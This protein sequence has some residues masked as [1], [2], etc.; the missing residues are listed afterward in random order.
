MEICCVCPEMAGVFGQAGVWVL[1]CMEAL[2][3]SNL[4]TYWILGFGRSQ[5]R[6]VTNGIIFLILDG[7]KW[8]GQSPSDKARLD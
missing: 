5:V 2:V 8:L 7:R 3:G 4:P 6:D 1:G